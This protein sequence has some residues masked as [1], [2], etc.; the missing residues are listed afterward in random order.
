M[1]DLVAQFD[2]K[3]AEVRALFSGQL[4]PNRATEIQNRLLA[5]GLPL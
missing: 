3:P 4:E 2:V 1:K 5:A